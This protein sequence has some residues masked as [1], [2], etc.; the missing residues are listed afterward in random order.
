MGF[1]RYYEEFELGDVYRHW[2]GRTITEH[3]NTWYAL[4]SLNQNPLYIDAHYA[5]KLGYEKCPV[6]DTLIFSL[7][8]GMSVSDTSG[9]TI[10]NLGF[11]R[12]KFEQPLFPGDSLYAETEVLG[13]RESKSKADRGIVHVET[14]AFNQKRERILVLRRSFL[15]PKQEERD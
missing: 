14:R 6:V 8:V 5:Q 13:K 15:A 10:A 4:L 2:P 3:D 12:V 7:V 11:E 1:G 9:K